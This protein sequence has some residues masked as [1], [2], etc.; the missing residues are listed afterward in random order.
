MI[1]KE[2]LEK[3]SRIAR[4]GLSDKESKELRKDLDSIMD[5]FR[6]IQ[7]LDTGR[8]TTY[9]TKERNTFREDG[10]PEKCSSLEDILR[11]VPEMDGK[12]VKVPKNL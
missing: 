11:N 12:H 7:K 2:T 9:V 8:E 10:R 6:E 1:D 4:I 3:V 5:H